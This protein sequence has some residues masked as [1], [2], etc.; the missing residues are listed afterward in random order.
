MILY[1]Y[2]D[3]K[4]KYINTKS[5]NSHQSFRG[6]RACMRG[7]PDLLPCREAEHFLK[8]LFCHHGDDHA[9]DA[10][11]THDADGDHGGGGDV[12]SQILTKLLQSSCSYC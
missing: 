2:I 6:L 3:I 8:A 12:E 7:V 10:D 5:T 4:S 11:E 9:D 1:K